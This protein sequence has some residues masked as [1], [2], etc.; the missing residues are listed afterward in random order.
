MHQSTKEFSLLQ[1]YPLR[2]SERVLAEI[3]MVVLYENQVRTLVS[4]KAENHGNF[5]S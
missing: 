1:S 4:H 5:F 3:Y 2:L